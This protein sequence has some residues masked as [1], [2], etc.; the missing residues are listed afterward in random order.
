MTPPN[1]FIGLPVSDGWVGRTVHGAPD[2]LRTFWGD[3]IHVTL[4]FLGPCGHQAAQAAWHALVGDRDQPLDEPVIRAELGPIE[5]FGPPAQPSSLSVVP[6]DPDGPMT[7]L[8]ARHRDRLRQAAGLNPE[9]RPPRPHV[10]V[11][12][13]PRNAPPGLRQAAIDWASAQ[14]PVGVTVVLGEVALYTWNEDRSQL[15]YHIVERR[16]MRP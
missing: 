16:P 8:L 9:G 14:P 7:A 2:G 12:R 10:T 15:L 3:D 5:P 1:F 11:A 13:I 4:A 6:V